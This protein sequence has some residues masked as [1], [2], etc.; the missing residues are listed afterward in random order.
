MQAPGVMEIEVCTFPF[1]FDLLLLS[2]FVYFYNSCRYVGDLHLL[3]YLFLFIFVVFV[4][5]LCPR[6]YLPL[7]TLLCGIRWTYDYYL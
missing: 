2:G 5:L 1:W 7:L 4:Y 3:M 6:G